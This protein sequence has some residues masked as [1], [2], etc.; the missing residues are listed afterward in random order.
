MKALDKIKQSRFDTFV[1]DDKNPY[2]CS[3]FVIELENLL[4]VSLSQI[5]P[6]MITEGDMTADEI[7]IETEPTKVYDRYVFRVYDNLPSARP[8]DKM[9]KPLIETSR[10][11]MDYLYSNALDRIRMYGKDK[12]KWEKYI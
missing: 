10:Q 7:S 1:A 9:M 8:D 3:R 4:P 5:K 12:E 6:V 2:I 11:Y